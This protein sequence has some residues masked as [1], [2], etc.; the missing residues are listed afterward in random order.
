MS[1]QCD[2]VSPISPSNIFELIGT[3]ITRSQIKELE[4]SVIDL[5]ATARKCDQV[6]KAKERVILID[7]DDNDSPPVKWRKTNVRNDVLTVKVDAFNNYVVS[8]FEKIFGHLK[9]NKTNEMSDDFPRSKGW[10]VNNVGN[11]TSGL[12][13]NDSFDDSH[14]VAPQQMHELKT[15]VDQ[16]DSVGVK[17]N[18]EVVDGLF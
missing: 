18:E 7:E 9:I 10:Q 13:D 3:L 4:N 16:R 8:S 2:F 5:V 11:A 12:V 6:K 17:Q 14:D 1:H 15:L